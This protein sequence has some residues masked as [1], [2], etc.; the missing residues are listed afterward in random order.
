M[1]D[2]LGRLVPRKALE[3]HDVVLFRLNALRLVLHVNMYS[4]FRLTQVGRTEGVLRRHVASE[5]SRCPAQIARITVSWDEEARVGR[6]SPNSFSGC[7]SN[8]AVHL[9]REARVP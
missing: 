4:P 5:L 1:G 2:R 3:K 8:D 7:R 6:G 9:P